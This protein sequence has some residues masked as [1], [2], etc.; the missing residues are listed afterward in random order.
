MSPSASGAHS[1]STEPAPLANTK[2]TTI[3]GLVCQIIAQIVETTSTRM[4]I[5]IMMDDPRSCFL[6]LQSAAPSFLSVNHHQITRVKLMSARHRLS[7]QNVAQAPTNATLVQKL[8]PGAKNHSR[9]SLHQWLAC[10][11]SRGASSDLFM[12]DLRDP[13]QEAFVKQNRALKANK[14]T[15]RTSEI[16][17]SVSHTNGSRD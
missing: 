9:S 3:N 10:F 4:K 12:C 2:I 6:P 11:D 1:A 16:R 17:T 14:V 8:H 13:Q 5:L 7:C 15:R